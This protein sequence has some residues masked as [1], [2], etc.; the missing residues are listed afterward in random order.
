MVSF[1]STTYTKRKEFSYLFQITKVLLE[2]SR[3]FVV[4]HVC[5]QRSDYVV[6]ETRVEDIFMKVRHCSFG[7]SRKDGRASST[8]RLCSYALGIRI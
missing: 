1:I 2:Y 5:L 4:F 3:Q 7:V 6:L 8:L